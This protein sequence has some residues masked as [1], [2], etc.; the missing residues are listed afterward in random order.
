MG[1]LADDLIHIYRDVALGQCLYDA[2]RI[3]D[4]IWQWGSGFQTQ[5]GQHAASA[6]RALHC[7][8]AQEDPSGLLNDS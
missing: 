1:D 2:G 8:L 3:D 7:Y 4:A 5:W 6:I